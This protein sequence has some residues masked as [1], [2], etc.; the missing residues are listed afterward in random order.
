MCC[1]TRYYY[2]NASGPPG[3]S[4]RFEVILTLTLTLTPTLTLTLTLGGR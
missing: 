1:V 2:H 4:M 3:A